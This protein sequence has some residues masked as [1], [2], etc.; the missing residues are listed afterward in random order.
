MYKF[1][2]GAQKLDWYTEWLDAI[3][4]QRRSWPSGLYSLR[5]VTVVKLGQ[6]R[7]DSGWAASEVGPRN[8]PHRPSE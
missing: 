7:S 2:T 5:Q 6:V 8:S 4:L 3:P 1:N